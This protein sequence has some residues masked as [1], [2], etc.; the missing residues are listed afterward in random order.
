MKDWKQILLNIYTPEIGSVW[1]VHNGIWNNLF[2]SNKYSNDYHPAVVGKINEDKIS[3]KIIPGTTKEYLK[4][5]GVFKVRFN[6]Y[7]PDYQITHFLINLWMTISNKEL[8][9]MKRGWDG[10]EMLN[11]TQIKGLKMQIKFYWGIDV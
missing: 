5:T 8:F 6:T 1:A 3:C 4:G 2:A 10:V 11:E 9:K 7:N